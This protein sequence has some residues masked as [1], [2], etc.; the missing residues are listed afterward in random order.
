MI[1]VID[2]NL[3]P[4]RFP[5]LSEVLI[6]KIQANLDAG[7]KILLTLNRRGAMSTLVCRDCGWAARC[8]SCDLMMRV[9]HTPQHKLLCHLC[10]VS[11]NIPFNCPKCWGNHLVESGARV[12]NIDTNIRKLFPNAQ[13]LL[14]EK[15]FSQVSQKAL[16]EGNIFVWTQKIS[17]LPIENLGLTAF[18]LVESDLAVP[19]YNIE[20]EVYT[21]VRYFFHRS[22]EIVLQTRSPKL[23]LIQD[24]VSSNFRTF[25][26]HTVNERKQFR[27]PPFTQ[28]AMITITEAG[29]SALKLR[30]G[31][32][33]SAMLAAAKEKTDTTV[34]YDHMLSERRQGKYMQKIL[35]RWPDLLQFL[36]P[37]RQ[38]LVRG[39]GIEV[40]WL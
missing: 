13:V 37:F 22:D 28:M 4:A 24:I 20:E 31:T 8:P 7:K 36:E 38:Q 26:Q 2:L 12:Q 16:K 29:E 18:L 35:I 6:E 17:S 5:L 10:E 19:V 9:H 14:V 33:A 23:S 39:R 30:V 27:L 15:D 1:T 11:G 32:L 21:H 40:E 3:I 25:F 34:T